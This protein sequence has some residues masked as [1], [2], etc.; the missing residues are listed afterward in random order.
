MIPINK[1]VQKIAV[2]CMMV[3]LVQTSLQ[4]QT[5]QPKW[6]FGISGGANVNFY[7]GTTQRL[8]SSLIVPA[9]FHKGDGIKPF[10]SFLIEYRPG[11]VWGGLLNLGYDGRGGK[12]YD[13]IAPCDCPATLKT[14]ASYL[15]IEPSLRFSPGGGNFYLFAGPRVGIN[16]EKDFSYTQLKQPNTDAE[17]SEMRKTVISGQAGIGYDI[18]VSSASSTTKFVISPFVSY[19]PYFG[20]DV[21]SIESWSVS[22]VRAGIAL[23]L[24]KGKKIVREETQTV[25]PVAP[26]AD[27]SFV[28]RPPKAI[29]MKRIVSETLP[30]LN[31]V[32]FDEG[33]AGI[34]G[35]YVTLSKEQ[36]ERFKEI[37]L[38]EEQSA[39]L[40][41]RSARQLN[42]Y[43]NVLNIIGDRMR[44]NP[45][46]KITLSGASL[47]GA[48]EGELFASNLK[49]YLVDVFQIDPSRIATNGRIKPLI[50][51]EQPGGNKELALLRAG[52]RRVDIQSTSPELMMEVGGGMMKPVQINTTQSDPMDSHVVFNV[53][54]AEDILSSYSIDLTDESGTIQ[55]YGPFTKNQ[56][57]IAGKTILG[58]KKSGDYKVVLSGTTKGG[59]AIRKEGAVHLALQE[60]QVE[61][62]LRHSILFNFNKSTTVATYREFLENVVSPLIADGSTV[63][64]HGHTDIIGTE[65]Y[66]TKL[67][68]RRA[69]QAQQILEASLT[70]A[71][72]SNVKF[73]TSGLGE[74]EDKSP[75]DNNTP[76]E[77]F[78][79]RTV[80]IDI[81]SYK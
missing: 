26:V 25:A 22:T 55:H 10:G 14:N 20:Q 33:A 1:I 8:N 29:L 24:G 80:I 46:A 37:Q 39:P 44:S 17:F 53:G 4:A 32:F 31:Y 73:E 3:L 62:G 76:E 23:K 28:V 38:Q 70:K 71:G 48:D 16:L 60:E 12:F 2:C 9:A 68:D 40:T 36:A 75:F 6:W 67:S 45:Q 61:N 34:P 47:K 21:R 64:I 27:V 15:T 42:I 13:V 54:R 59:A 35:R 52:D 41:G 51:S 30:L 50:P 18:Q 11:N 77:R 7:E 74:T 5:T 43:Y 19:H 63:I 56:E 65:D 66:N 72:K 69:K 78:Y 57:S 81:V 58:D 79:N 49:T